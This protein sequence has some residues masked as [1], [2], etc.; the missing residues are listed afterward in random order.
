MTAHD[1]GRPVWRAPA[2]LGVALALCVVAGIVRAGPL[3]PSSLWLDDAWVALVSKTTGVSDT[4]MVGLTGPGFA[5]LL[6]GWL[7]LVGFSE[8]AAQLPA[9]VFAVLAP[10]VLYLV[11]VTRG[12]SPAGAVVA[13]GLLVAAPVH[14]VYATRVKHYTLDTLLAVALIGLAWAVIAAPTPRRWVWLVTVAGVAVMLSGGVAPVAVGCLAGA[15]LASLRQGGRAVRWAVAGCGV[16]L[17]IALTWYVAVLRPAITP[18]IR[19]YWADRYVASVRELLIGLGGLL[20]GFSALPVALGAVA[21]VG[22]AV[23]LALRRPTLLVVCLGPV[24]ALAVL[25]VL[26][27]APLGGGRTD[28]AL[29]PGLALVVGALLGG[30]RVT[31]DPAV[32][33][34]AWR[35]LA[36]GAA[37]ALAAVAIVVTGAP[38]PYPQEDVRPLVARLAQ[39]RADD[40]PVLVYP[41][42]IWAYA[43]YTRAPVSLETDRA[44]PWG[45]RPEVD[46]GGVTL[47]EAHREEPS[48]YVAAVN[49]AVAGADSV[50]LLASHT[51]ADV[52]AVR[53][54]LRAAELRPAMSLPT[55]GADITRWDR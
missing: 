55:M 46:D 15:G 11:A 25:A 34:S 31:R 14:Q 6:K 21:A 35:W 10:G 44:S 1:T 37:A 23:V 13:A 20:E 8:S 48:R 41:S 28:A 50:W 38:P 24:A 33:S 16:W 3:G 45:F 5:F 7:A 49:V 2:H 53:R 32:H 52:R 30:S 39:V 12:F 40:E 9:F 36:P 29:Y 17:L 54:A 22:G 18:A 42:T 51:R 47:L 27:L 43:L 26:G 4:F 19:G